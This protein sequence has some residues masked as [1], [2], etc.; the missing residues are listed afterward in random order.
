MELS[1]REMRDAVRALVV[2]KLHALLS[3][4]TGADPV[5]LSAY[6]AV[7]QAAAFDHLVAN[8]IISG[9]SYELHRLAAAVDHVGIPR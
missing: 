1:Q 8:D 7:L 4:P 6:A 3:Q 2:M 9:I 5:Y